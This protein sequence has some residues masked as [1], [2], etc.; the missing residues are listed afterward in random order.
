MLKFLLPAQK[1][2]TLT[3]PSIPLP[4]PLPSPRRTHSASLQ[5]VTHYK[6]NMGNPL[7]CHWYIGKPIAFH[8]HRASFS[9]IHCKA[10]MQA[11]LWVFLS[12]CENWSMQVQRTGHCDF[13]YDLTAMLFAFPFIP[14]PYLSCHTSIPHGTGISCRAR[15]SLLKWTSIVSF[16][17][18]TLFGVQHPQ[19]P[20]DNKGGGLHGNLIHSI[21][22]SNKIWIPIS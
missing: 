20:I 2:Q 4:S 8:V 1:A 6:T 3:A 5:V 10:A 12:P 22:I 15:T 14:C 11:E 13:C 18:S 19:S 7:S 21:R 16:G 17:T 9:S